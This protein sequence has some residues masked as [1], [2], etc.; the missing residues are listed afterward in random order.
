MGRGGGRGR[1]GRSHRL[2][3]AD[4]DLHGRRPIAPGT[5]PIDINGKCNT[6]RGSAAVIQAGYAEGGA[7]ESTDSGS[8]VVT[9]VGTSVTGSYSAVLAFGDGGTVTG[10]FDVPICPWPW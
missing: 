6:G 10:T 7:Y 4:R 5:Y 9:S 2:F 3:A 8:V 1:A